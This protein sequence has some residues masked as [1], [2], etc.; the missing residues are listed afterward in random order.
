MKRNAGSST[1]K[2]LRMDRHPI[3]GSLA[4]TADRLTDAKSGGAGVLLVFRDAAL[5]TDPPGQLLFVPFETPA[6][7]SPTAFSAPEMFEF[8]RQPTGRSDPHISAA[9]RS[10]PD[11][12]GARR[13]STQACPGASS[14]RTHPGKP[15]SLATPVKRSDDRSNRCRHSRTS[16]CISR[17]RRYARSPRRTPSGSMAVNSQPV[18]VLLGCGNQDR[19]TTGGSTRG[20]GGSVECMEIPVCS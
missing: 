19:A 17:T 11:P 13:S 20:I 4:E 1:S 3:R 18:R 6:A 7:E 15:G 9:R 12:Y 2:K 16:C 5:T 10:S 8:V 14:D